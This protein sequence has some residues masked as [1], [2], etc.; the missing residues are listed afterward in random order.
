MGG[1]GGGGGGGGYSYSFHAQTHDYQSRTFGAGENQELQRRLHFSKV[2]IKR[3][4]HLWESVDGNG[5]GKGE[6]GW[7]EE[8]TN[9][10]DSYQSAIFG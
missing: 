5:R 6:G 2:P 1:G 3:A 10:N 7:G 9:L 8:E 4:Q